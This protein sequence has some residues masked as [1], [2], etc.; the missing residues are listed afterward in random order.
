MIL[1]LSK[2]AKKPSFFNCFGFE[3]WHDYP[4]NPSIIELLVSKNNKEFVTWS[5]I[6]AKLVRFSYIFYNL[7]YIK[8]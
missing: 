2:A 5:V 7:N 3:C 1:D 8:F 4:T 6:H